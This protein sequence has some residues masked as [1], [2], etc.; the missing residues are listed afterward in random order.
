MRPTLL[1]GD[2]FTDA[3]LLSHFRWLALTARQAD[4]LLKQ[5][6]R[7]SVHFLRASIIIVPRSVQHVLEIVNE[8]MRFLHLND[9]LIYE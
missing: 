6:Y 3:Y 1:P 9:M 4:Q 8:L 2:T 5:I 7:S